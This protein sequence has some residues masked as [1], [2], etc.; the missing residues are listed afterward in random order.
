MRGD[1]GDT[2]V[3]SITGMC[4]PVEE[5]VI[6]AKLASI[7]GIVS[8]NFNLLQRTLKVEHEPA[9]LSAISAALE[10]LAMGAKLV[11]TESSAPAPVSAPV[12]WVRLGVAGVAA[13][14]S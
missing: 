12:N 7:K 3:F 10:S 1:T 14:A 11:D 4:C 9:A 5:G 2:S 13:T 6:R 8:L